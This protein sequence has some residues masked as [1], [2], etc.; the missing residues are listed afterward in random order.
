MRSTVKLRQLI[1]LPLVLT[2]LP[3]SPASAD[4]SVSPDL[5]VSA[6]RGGAA[7]APENTMMAFRNAVRLGADDLEADA[8][9]TGDGQLILIHDDTLDR[10]TNCSGF[11]LDFTYEELKRCDAAYHFSPGEPTTKVNDAAPTPLRTPEAELAENGPRIPLPLVSELFDYLL[12]LHE[13]EGRAPTATVELKVVPDQRDAEGGRR[14][15]PTSY[16]A[17]NSLVNLINDPK[18]AAVKDRIIVQSFWPPALEVVKALDPSIPTLFLSTF[19]AAT[20]AAKNLLYTVARGHDF[21]APEFKSPDFGPEFMQFANGAGTP[22]IPWTVD[23]ASDLE[24]VGALGVAGMITNFPG[25]MLALQG[26]LETGTKMTP[27][28]VPDTAPCP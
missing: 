10:T 3:L 2:W 8:L 20:L 24:Q 5:I 4:S 1:G 9:M 21:S 27:D 26:R 6:H 18:Y 23:K 25:C 22:V 14:M 15:D 19:S 13:S 11:V 12:E 16:A 28:E 7:Y 17:A